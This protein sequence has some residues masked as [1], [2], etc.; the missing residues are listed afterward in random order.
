LGAIQKKPGLEDAGNIKIAHI[1]RQ[2]AGHAGRV[3]C[4]SEWSVEQA[5]APKEMLAKP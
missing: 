3:V 4:C 1:Q 5:F 2:Q